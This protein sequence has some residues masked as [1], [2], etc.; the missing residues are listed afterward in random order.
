MLFAGNKSLTMKAFNVMHEGLNAAA[1]RHKVIANNI[2]NVN[3]PGFKRSMVGFESELKR[4][5]E[6]NGSLSALRNHSKH[7]K[8]KREAEDLEKIKPK[9]FMENDTIFRNDN[10]NVDM[11]VEMANLAKNN[12]LYDAMV[13][14]VRRDLGYLRQIITTGGSQ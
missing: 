8:F 2:A 3:T 11:D 5:L 1:V 13:T 4:A 7:I 14:G 12:I 6:N 10:N 9:V